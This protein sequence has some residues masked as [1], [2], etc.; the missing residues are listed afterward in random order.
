MPVATDSPQQLLTSKQVAS[1]LGVTEQT[2]A[3]WRS[4]R[5]RPDL[6]FL[7]ISNRCVRY[8]VSDVARFIES[9][10]VGALPGDDA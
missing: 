4:T 6:P 10:V 3:H 8:R 1:L 2:L 9:N 7:P 5:S